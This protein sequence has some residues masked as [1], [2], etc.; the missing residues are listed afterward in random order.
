MN[1]A[2]ISRGPCIHK[3]NRDNTPRLVHYVSVE[4]VR[5]EEEVTAFTRPKVP[6]FRQNSPENNIHRAY[7][8]V[9]KLPL[10]KLKINDKRKTGWEVELL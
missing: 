3:I 6:S 10:T 1:I 4:T 7:R 8:F 5:R 2:P 9:E